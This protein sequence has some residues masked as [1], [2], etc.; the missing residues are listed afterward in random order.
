[1]IDHV[2]LGYIHPLIV[3]CMACI[4]FTS[5]RKIAFILEGVLTVILFDCLY[6]Y[7]SIGTCLTCRTVSANKF[8]MQQLY[9]ECMPHLK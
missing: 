2:V 4:I 9:S 6:I 3:L 7:T 1:M 5:T 8:I